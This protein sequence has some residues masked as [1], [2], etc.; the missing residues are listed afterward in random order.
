MDEVPKTP[1]RSRSRSRSSR[2]RVRRALTSQKPATSA[3]RLISQAKGQDELPDGYYFDDSAGENV[4]IYVI[5]TGL[6]KTHEVSVLSELDS[7][8]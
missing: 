6:D 1:P 2:S 8:C 5:D 4:R 7:K 3:L